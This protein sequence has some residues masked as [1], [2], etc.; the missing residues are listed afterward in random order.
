MEYLGCCLVFCLFCLKVVLAFIVQWLFCPML[1]ANG[2]LTRCGQRLR[3]FSSGF[4]C[5]IARVDLFL[6][7]GFEPCILY[8][9]ILFSIP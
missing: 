6:I 9:K 7:H 3:A 2:Y 1:I 8:W 4:G 5:H